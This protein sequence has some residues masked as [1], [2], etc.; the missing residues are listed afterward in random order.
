MSHPKHDFMLL[1]GVCSRNRA[2]VSTRFP[3][4]CIAYQTCYHLIEQASHICMYYSSTVVAKPIVN[5]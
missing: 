4:I 1:I 5:W 3:M 2:N